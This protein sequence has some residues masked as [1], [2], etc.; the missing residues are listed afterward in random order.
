MDLHSLCQRCL[1]PGK[2]ASRL[3]IFSHLVTEVLKRRFGLLNPAHSAGLSKPN[4][5]LK[6]GIRY[7]TPK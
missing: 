6:R 7:V 1:S 5:R 3:L 2:M 4:L